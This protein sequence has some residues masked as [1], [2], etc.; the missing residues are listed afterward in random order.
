MGSIFLLFVYLVLLAENPT[1]TLR[2]TGGIILL[3]FA[4]TVFETKRKRS[5]GATVLTEKAK[6]RVY[7]P[8]LMTLDDYE[9]TI[10]GRR[11]RRDQMTCPHCGARFSAA[12][13]DEEEFDEEEDEWEA[14]DEE[15]GI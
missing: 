2:W 7:H 12:E 5:G 9:C 14:W 8:H 1:S 4:V 3:I 10:C 13:T 6:A 15:D 11:F